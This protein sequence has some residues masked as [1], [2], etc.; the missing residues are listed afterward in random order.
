[1]RNGDE[2][3]RIEHARAQEGTDTA[4]SNRDW[5]E[6]VVCGTSVARARSVVCRDADDQRGPYLRR[7]AEVH[8]PDLAPAW[9]RHSGWSR[10][11]RSVNRRSAAASK[12]SSCGKS[13]GANATRRASSA[14]SSDRS[15][16][17]SAS[18]SS[19][20]FWVACVTESAAPVHDHAIRRRLQAAAS[21]LGDARSSSELLRLAVAWCTLARYSEARIR[22][23]RASMN[24]IEARLYTLYS[25]ALVGIGDLLKLSNGTEIF[26]AEKSVARDPEARRTLRSPGSP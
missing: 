25:S 23:L 18:N 15:R 22:W 13:C 16:S 26:T 9:R 2:I 11:S 6:L 5:R 21:V 3:L 12:S 1:V 14:T 19:I 8:Q 4:A 24:P 10:R 17:G 20:N 7:Y